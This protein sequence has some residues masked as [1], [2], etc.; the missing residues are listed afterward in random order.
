LARSGEGA[1][2]SAAVN[3]LF[4]IEIAGLDLRDGSSGDTAPDEQQGLRA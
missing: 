2:F 4:G 1:S 3:A